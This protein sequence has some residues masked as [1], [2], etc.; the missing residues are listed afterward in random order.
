MISSRDQNRTEI[1]IID[2]SPAEE[3]GEA[4]AKEGRNRKHGRGETGER[5]L[6]EGDGRDAENRR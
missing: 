5:S 4:E 1:E 2:R 6:S 3:T